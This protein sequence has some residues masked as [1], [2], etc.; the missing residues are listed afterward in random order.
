MAHD[1]FISYSSKDKPTADAACAKLE[2][3]QIR[4]WM[5]PRDIMPG[6]D[7]SSSIIDDINGARTMVLVFSA[8]A[9]ASA[10]IKRE[11]ERAVNKGIPVIPLRIENVAPERSLE[12]FIST[13][14][15]LD[16]FTTP[17]DHHLNYL[18]DV[19]RHILDGEAVPEAPPPP[20]W[21]GPAGYAVAGAAVLVVAVAIWFA[22]LRPPPGFIGTWTATQLDTRQFT[23][24]NAMLASEVPPQLLSAALKSSA[25]KGSLTVQASGQFSLTVSGADQGSVTASPATF[26][27][28]V[29]N[30]TFT[31]DVTHTSLTVGLDLFK[32]GSD[33]S[34]SGYQ[35]NT[36][37]PPN[38][39]TPFQL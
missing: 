19:I 13:P 27:Q 31:S 1:V 36:D 14:H 8:N 21:R 37:P 23:T 7:W 26:S 33:G 28:S 17:L 12:Y 4:C 2:A 9:N 39:Q 34:V 18:A 25:E 35:P 24:E 29:N 3:R 16:A 11:V 10:Q 38:G 22:A 32:T 6:A 30:L 15:W 20:W 5:A